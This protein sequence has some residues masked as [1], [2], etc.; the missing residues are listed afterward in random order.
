MEENIQR[1]VDF[2]NFALMHPADQLV[3]IMERIYSY[4]MTTTSGGN[5]S[6]LDENGDIW[7]TP[8]GIDKGSLTRDDMVR[9]TPEGEV[10][11]RHKPSSEFPFHS[12]V[13][14]MRPDIKAVLHAH[15]PA[16]LGFSIAR[17]IPNTNIIPNID[18]ICGKV[19]YAPYELPG[20]RE[21][22]EN[23]AGVFEKGF[24]SVMLENH[25]IVV[26]KE[27]LFKAFE[28]FETLDFCARIELQALKIGKVKA[29]SDKEIALSEAKN[30]LELSEFVPK[31]VKSSEKEA[32][33]SMCRLIERAYHQRLFTSTQG[34]FSERTEDGGFIITPFGKDRKYLESE[35]LVKIKG[36]MK[37]LSK[38][39]SRSALFHKAVYD[40]HPEINSIILAHPPNLMAFA[41][42]DAEMDSR[43]IPESYIMLRDVKKLPF[44]STYYEPE[45]TAKEVG[46]KNPVT[47]IKNECCVVMGTSLLNAF[48]RLE[49][50]EYSAKAIINASSL[51]SLVKIDD[52]EIER[53]IK[54]FKLKK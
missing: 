32:R 23:I 14:K 38:N 1:K 27:D 45:K 51:G 39:P 35:D 4:G 29:L 19:A 10:I 41:I 2:M 54:A 12:I 25:G 44:G 49:V 7:I 30:N 36:D 42:S 18:S 52:S 31:I 28:A 5:L 47:L 37:E 48:D 50:A 11:G 16:L 13:Y 8:A 9:V 6:I 21:L 53:I 15:P 46:I 17:K 43:I 40:M 26:G 24:D 33:S 20:S 22:S 3:L 34:T